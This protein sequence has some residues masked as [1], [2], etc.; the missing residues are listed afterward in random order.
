MN[1]HD[2]YT[3]RLVLA[4]LKSHCKCLT[5]ELQ[6]LLTEH[7]RANIT[8]EIGECQRHIDYLQQEINNG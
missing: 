4:A 8:L 3:Q 7:E 5:R 2:I 1:L 6:L